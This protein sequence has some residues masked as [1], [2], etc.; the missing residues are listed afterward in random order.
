MRSP[1]FK[2]A[3]AALAALALAL[4]VYSSFRQSQVSCEVCISYAGTSQC[5]TASGTTRE[6]AI[7][8][9]TNNAC[10]YIS[11][12]MSDSIRCGNTPPSRVTCDP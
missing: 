2:I 10:T 6:E 8:T 5:R 11:S 1:Q 9:A 7:R 4:I 3:F 12:G